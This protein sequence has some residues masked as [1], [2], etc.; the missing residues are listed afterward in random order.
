MGNNLGLVESAVHSLLPHHKTAHHPIFRAMEECYERKTVVEHA[1]D[2]ITLANLT[3]QMRMVLFGANGN[4]NKVSSEILGLYKE[5]TRG[6]FKIEIQ[7]DPAKNVE[8]KKYQDN[9]DIALEKRTW[10][11]MTIEQETNPDNEDTA[12]MNYRMEIHVNKIMTDILKDLQ[13]IE[14]YEE[15]IKTWPGKIA[16]VYSVLLACQDG[17]IRRPNPVSDKIISRYMDLY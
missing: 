9:L 8:M 1:K 11:V 14:Q 7:D 6:E 12:Y 2:L 10:P 5:V 13:S 17:L 16:H 15:R 3:M 4:C